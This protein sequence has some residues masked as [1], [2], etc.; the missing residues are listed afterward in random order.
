MVLFL[1]SL[2]TR[3]PRVS[4]VDVTMREAMGMENELLP[5]HRNCCL[6]LSVSP[7]YPNDQFLEHHFSL[8]YGC[9]YN[10]TFA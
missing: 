8:K 1:E 3:W 9:A 6:I 4:R 10:G 5:K 2:V 7:Q